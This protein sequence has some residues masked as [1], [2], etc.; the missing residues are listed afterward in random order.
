MSILG[1]HCMRRCRQI[2]ICCIQNGIFIL[3]REKYYARENALRMQHELRKNS[4][5]RVS[6]KWSTCREEW[7]VKWRLFL[8]V[9]VYL[10]HFI[11]ALTYQKLL[12]ALRVIEIEQ[13]EKRGV[14][15]RQGSRHKMR[16]SAA[17]AYG[18]VC[19]RRKS[20]TRL[21]NFNNLS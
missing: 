8:R 12:R 6:S 20:N 18:M 19:Y 4:T 17:R 2:F 14:P 15:V 5:R 1:N 3:V 11:F 10:S 21:F 13:E 9:R 7:E 16:S